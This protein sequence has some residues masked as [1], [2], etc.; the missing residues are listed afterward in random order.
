MGKSVLHGRAE[1]VKESYAIWKINF[2]L[3][4]IM[5]RSYRKVLKKDILNR[6]RYLKCCVCSPG[7][8]SKNARVSHKESKYFFLLI[9][10]ALRFHLKAISCRAG[11]PSIEI[12]E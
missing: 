1:A 5:N 10:I 7:A 8:V 11:A 3:L 2:L 4:S 6:N 9:L 12:N